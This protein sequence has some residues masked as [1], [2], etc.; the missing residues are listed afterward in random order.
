M[1]SYELRWEIAG[2]V[3]LA[4]AFR[5]L[6]LDL[7][8]YREPLGDLA[9]L[10]YE[11]NRKQFAAE[12]RPPWARLS[13][14]YRR[15]KE[16]HFPGRK[17]MNRTG[18]LEASLTDR[19]SSGAI[20]RLTSDELEIGTKLMVGKYN[21]GLIHQKPLRSRLPQ[22]SLMDLTKSA[23][24]ES[25]RIFANWFERKGREAGVGR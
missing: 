5:S 13:A 6:A 11:E 4:R 14:G 24:N 25:T 21:L 19:R 15:W 8:D 9:D 1:S 20:F 23:Q 22:R 3:Q 10:I 17:I 16:R 7:R 2:E 12:G 18:A